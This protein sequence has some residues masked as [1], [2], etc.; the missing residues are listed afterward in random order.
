ML[1][2]HP[3]YPGQVCPVSPAAFAHHQKRGWRVVD[4]KAVEAKVA[5]EA[6]V[7]EMKVPEPKVTAKS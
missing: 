1:M 2:E 7:A 3:A 4:E 5:V 6:L